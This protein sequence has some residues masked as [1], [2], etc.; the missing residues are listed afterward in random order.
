[1]SKL[2][3]LALTATASLP[4]ITAGSAATLEPYD[5]VSPYSNVAVV[6]AP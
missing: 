5:V 6:L 4:L 3:M 1:M 2:P